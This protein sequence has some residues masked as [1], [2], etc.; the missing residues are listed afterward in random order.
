MRGRS[1]K[2]MRGVPLTQMAVLELS[3]A[4]LALLPLSLATVDTHASPVL[5]AQRTSWSDVDSNQPY[6]CVLNLR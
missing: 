1:V 4:Q 2:A 3:P 5:S 6:R